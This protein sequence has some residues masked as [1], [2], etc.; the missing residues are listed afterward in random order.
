MHI[1][2]QRYFPSVCRNNGIQ[3]DHSWPNHLAFDWQIPATG[4][5][6]N[7]ETEGSEVFNQPTLAEFSN[8]P[9]PY[10]RSGL[11]T[12]GDKPTN[13][14]PEMVLHMMYL[15]GKFRDIFDCTRQL[16][17]VCYLRKISHWPTPI[18]R[19]W[20]DSSSGFELA[21]GCRSSITTPSGLRYWG[22]GWSGENPPWN[23][24]RRRYGNRQSYDCTRF[25]HRVSFPWTYSCSG[26]KPGCLVLASRS[27][28]VRISCSSLYRKE[29]DVGILWSWP[30]NRV[31]YARTHGMRPI[32]E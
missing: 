2:F 20:R 11:E 14:T 12:V 22:H 24:H 8:K 30:S 31:T 4:E 5:H 10:R 1:S 15:T 23:Y 18:C 25:T 6:H 19:H 26:A 21:C 9:F 17:S 7:P 27:N 28:K 29:Q 32:S 3:T 13:I 16:T